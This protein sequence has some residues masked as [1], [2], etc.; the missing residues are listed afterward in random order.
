MD[1]PELL[2][3][4]IVPMVNYAWD[5][6]FVRV[7]KNLK[8]IRDRGWGPLNYTL[9]N[10]DQIQ[11]TMTEL[12]STSHALMMKPASNTNTQSVQQSFS[13]ESTI[14]TAE[15]TISTLTDDVGLCMNYQSKVSEESSR[16]SNN[17][18]QIEFLHSKISCSN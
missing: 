17:R 3:T 10:E 1:K 16:H 7:E 6:S 11:A 5:R 18:L 2:P 12:E 9:L 13:H 14:N 15:E 4:N 8:A